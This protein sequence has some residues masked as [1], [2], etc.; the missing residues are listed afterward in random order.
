[1]YIIKRK[2]YLSIKVHYTSG[3]S[4]MLSK[5]MLRYVRLKDVYHVYEYFYI[6]TR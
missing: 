3:K 5:V 1:M 2:V 6:T 4:S